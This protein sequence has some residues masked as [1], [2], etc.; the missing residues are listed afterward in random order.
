MTKTKDSL[1]KKLNWNKEHSKENSEAIEA[2]EN[3]RS[4]GKGA[5]LSGLGTGED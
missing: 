1:E 4:M 5:K 2:K 3:K